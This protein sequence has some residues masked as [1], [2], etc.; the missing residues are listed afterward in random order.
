[1]KKYG[2]LSALLLLFLFQE[3]LLRLVNPVARL[4]F[5]PMNDYEITLAIH[6]TNTF[7]RVFF[8]NSA[9][10]S[11]FREAESVSGYVEFGLNWGKATYMLAMLERGDITINQS[12]VLGLNIFTLMD[13]LDSDPS[14]IW[15][16]GQF[17][18]YTFFYRDRIRNFITGALD[19]L[20]QR[21]FYIRR[22]ENPEKY[23]YFG[24]LTDEQ[25][26]S[27]LA[28]LEERFWGLP[29]S[30]FEENLKALE[31][32]AVFCY[33]NNIR[34]RVVWMP[35]NPFSPK[36]EIYEKVMYEANR[37]FDFHGIEV[38]DL[39][40]AFSREN[41]F[42]TGHFNDEIGAG[43]FTREIDLWLKK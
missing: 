43:N 19:N 17:E 25:M 36:P 6:G 9:V 14:Y 2:F 3:G 21:N 42:D 13:T 29:L 40:N 37:I 35:F 8:G 15:H 28:V 33:E 20:L 27:R 7:D 39:S 4:P 1:M 26:E 23:L 31:R 32:I 10:V 18:P 34:L 24:M 38:L 5:F 12:L 22:Y 16:M 41:F 11:A 30:D